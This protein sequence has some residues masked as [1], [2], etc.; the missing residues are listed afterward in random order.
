MSNIDDL[1]REIAEANVEGGER[2]IEEDGDFLV[3]TQEVRVSSSAN[4][5]TK[6]ALLWVV[7]FE[8]V[9]GGSTAH[10]NGSRRAWVA[11][12]T[13]YPKA[14]AAVK[15]HICASFG[16]DAVGDKGALTE[17]SA[18]AAHE[19]Q[20]LYGTLVRLTTEK[21]ITKAKLDFTVHRWS[22]AKEGEIVRRSTRPATA[23]WEIHPDSSEHAW[24]PATGAVV[25]KGE[26]GL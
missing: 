16:V 5:R 12:P 20:I 21:I 13:L 8:I 6:G 17:A 3:E 2:K 26:V 19:D 4:I 15:E 25:P 10:P 9:E 14:K 1:Y 7:T 23:G 24:C 11:K 18:R 22:P